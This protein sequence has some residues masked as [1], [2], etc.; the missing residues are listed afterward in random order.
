MKSITIFR[1]GKSGWDAAVSRDFDR[2]IN[3]RGVQGSRQMGAY[4]KREGL[5]FDAVYSSPAIRCLETLDA[6]WEGYGEILHPNWD[7][8]IY[9]ASGGSLLDVIIDLDEPGDHILLC[10]HNPGC[11]ELTLML[12]PDVKGD[13]V[14]DEIEEKFPT[15]ALCEISLPASNWADIKEGSG[16]I[17]RFMRPRDLDPTLGPG[18]D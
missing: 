11:E 12:T 5:R 2:P 13:I 15:A 1:H 7:K 3:E 14:R 17:T 6:F 4:A 16:S 8:R 9:L 18:M 10:G